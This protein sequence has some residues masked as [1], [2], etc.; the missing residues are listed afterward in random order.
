MLKHIWIPVVVIGTAGT[1]GLI[2]V[3]RGNLLDVLEQ[4]FVQTARFQGPH[5]ARV[6]VYK[7]AVRNALHPLVMQLGMQLPEIFSGAAI[8]SVVLNLPT[9]GEAYLVA[10]QAQDMFLAGSFLLI[11]TAL[12]IV[13]NIVADVL[14]AILDPRV[15]YE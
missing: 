1:A 4:Q 6:V 14:L 3:M 8:T 15:T 11:I 2:R 13:G 9:L 7:H 10:V 12:L 5:R